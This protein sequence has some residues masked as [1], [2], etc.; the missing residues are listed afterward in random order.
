MRESLGRRG[1]D[2]GADDD[3]DDDDDDDGDDEGKGVT[4]LRPRR[5]GQRR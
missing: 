1:V 2:V 5:E 4:W 3:D